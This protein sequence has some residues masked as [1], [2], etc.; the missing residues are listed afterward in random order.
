MNARLI[1]LLAWLASSVAAAQDAD[2]ANNLKTRVPEV[3]LSAQHDRMVE[4]GVG[5]AF[6]E[7]TLPAA[8]A[9]AGEPQPVAGRFGTQATVVGVFHRESAMAKTM[10]RD[11]Q[12][13]IAERYPAADGADPPVATFAI[14]TGMPAEQALEQPNRVK[15]DQPVLMDEDGSALTKLG[16]GRTPRV[17]VLDGDGQ[18]VWL[19]IEYSLATRREMKQTVTELAGKPAAE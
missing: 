12:L 2:D 5:D 6:P 1:V 9:P 4:A 10:L 11:L 8:S 7:M 14:A 16:K 3:L 18:I 17:Y 13:D 19:D 15:F